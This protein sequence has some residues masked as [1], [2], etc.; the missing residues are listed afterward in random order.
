MTDKQILKSIKALARG[1]CAN[2]SRGDCLMTDER[3]HL[4][5]PNYESIH[6]GAIDCDYFLECVLPADWDLNDLV[7]YALWYDEEDEEDLPSNMRRC[8]E[9]QKPFV[10]TGN[11]QKYCNACQHIV[12]R[13]QI[14]RRVQKCRG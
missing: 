12:R 3:C 2:Y 9:C 5:N 8:E 11:R 7:S 4:V 1:E 14:A 13:R 6:D 10:M